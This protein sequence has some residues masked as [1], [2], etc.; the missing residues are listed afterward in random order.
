MSYCS[1]AVRC[2][3]SSDSQL[4]SWGSGVGKVCMQ[5]NRFKASFSL[6]SKAHHIQGVGVIFTRD[7]CTGS[8]QVLLRARVSYG[9]SV[10]PSVS[11]GPVRIQAQVR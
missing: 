2:M 8:V 1:V 7:S 10:R 4:P 6:L 11:H 9:D 3:S 5:T